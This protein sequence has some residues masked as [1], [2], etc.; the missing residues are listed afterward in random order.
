MITKVRLFAQLKLDANLNKRKRRILW[1]IL[2]EISEG[3]LQF[4]WE[5]YLNDTFCCFHFFYSN[6]RSGLIKLPGWTSVQ[7]HF[8]AQ[9]KVGLSFELKKHKDLCD[10]FWKKF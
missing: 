8:S 4:L 6:K 3:I 1:S 9:L 10:Q 2:E 7:V 5:I